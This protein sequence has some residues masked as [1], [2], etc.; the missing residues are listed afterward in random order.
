MKKI[1]TLITVLLTVTI[2]QADDWK[3]E[4]SI[5]KD[6][7]TGRHHVIFTAK[8]LPDIPSVWLEADDTEQDGVEMRISI[9][10]DTYEYLHDY[11]FYDQDYTRI[12]PPNYGILLREEYK[13]YTSRQGEACKLQSVFIANDEPYFYIHLSDGP[14]GEAV[15][16]GFTFHGTEYS[17]TDL[18]P[19]A[20]D[21]QAYFL[22]QLNE[23][24]NEI[25]NGFYT[26][27]AFGF[28]CQIAEPAGQ[29]STE[30]K[31]QECT[32]QSVTKTE[33]TIR[34]FFIQ[35]TNGV[36]NKIAEYGF[37]FRNTEY[38]SAAPLDE[39]GDKYTSLRLRDYH[40]ELPNGDYTNEV[41]NFHCT[42]FEP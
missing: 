25:A 16:Y 9:S 8:D 13:L 33:E 40:Y 31:P 7:S 17:Q 39:N 24:H 30:E 27:E 10:T 29:V 19:L 11:L 23:E 26:Y 15:R 22:M 42:L 12:F 18:F 14:D 2:A 37:T 34:D 38:S 20:N 32:L 3:D 41:T 4:L 35:L 1:G 6:D 28:F 5:F 21:G 36:P